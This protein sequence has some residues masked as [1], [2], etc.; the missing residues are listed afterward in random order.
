MPAKVKYKEGDIIGR[1]TYVKDLPSK[2]MGGQLRRESLF[3]CFCGKEFKSNLYSI[4][5]LSVKSCG[6]SILS[7]THGLSRTPEY[8]IWLAMKDRCLNVNNQ[9]YSDYGGR[10][11]KVC[12]SWLNSFQNFISDIGFRPSKNHSIDRYPNN[13]G[14]YEPTNI[15]WAT[16]SEQM[17]NVRNNRLLTYNG[18]TKTLVEWS[19][20]I[21]MSI[22]GL[23][24]RIDKLKWPLERALTYKKRI[25]SDEY[26][27]V[28]SRQ[29]YHKKKAEISKKRQVV[30]NMKKGIT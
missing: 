11:I 10:G 5:S 23:S 6:C 9:H 12:D 16:Q 7:K 24:W 21:G 4:T 22:T 25:L 2:F 8:A 14:N 17:R 3:K 19:E 29:L 18:E 1:I 15:R 30:R 28:K 27:D 20:I 13:N 26:R